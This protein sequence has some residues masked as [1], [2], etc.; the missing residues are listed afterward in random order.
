MP[1]TYEKGELPAVLDMLAAEAVTEGGK[2]AC[3][4]L[5]PSADRLEACLL[6][7][8]GHCLGREHVQHDGKLQ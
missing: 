1:S 8:L 7:S 4:K 2:E 3:L 5:R 6:A